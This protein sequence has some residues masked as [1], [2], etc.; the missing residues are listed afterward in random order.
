MLPDLPYPVNKPKILFVEGCRA[1]FLCAMVGAEARPLAATGF[2]L[3]A[4][5]EP[6]E[7]QRGRQ[8]PL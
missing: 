3:L 1:A 2:S 5:F 4:S 7:K 8:H 6:E